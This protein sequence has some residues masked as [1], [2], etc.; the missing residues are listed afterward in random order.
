MLTEAD[1]KINNGSR[2][3]SG[4]PREGGPTLS[5][6]QP[7][8]PSRLGTVFS[9]IQGSVLPS[10]PKARARVV[11]SL[12]MPDCNL[13]WPELWHSLGSS[14]RMDGFL[15][16]LCWFL[17]EGHLPRGSRVRG[18]PAQELTKM[19]AGETKRQ[20]IWKKK[21]GGNPSIIWMS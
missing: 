8:V 15:I 12:H 13:P 3:P 2:G 19:I 14:D 16:S 9:Q 4:D 11:L 1:T 6:C 18:R 17:R 10:E 21:G 20:Q 7:A 5:C